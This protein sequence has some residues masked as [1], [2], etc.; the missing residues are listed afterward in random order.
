MHDGDREKYLKKGYEYFQNRN[1]NFQASLR[2]YNNQNRF[3]SNSLFTR[4]LANGEK[5]DR[6]WL[7]YSE[8]TGCVFCYVCKLFSTN[9]NEESKFVKNGFS[10]WKKAK[11]MVNLHENSQEH[12]NCMITWL[13]RTNESNLINKDLAQMVENEIHYWTDVLKRV[14]TVI[15]F[16]A[17]RGL[18]FR[19]EDEVIGSANNG[20]Y[21]GLL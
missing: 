12:K 3:I 1:A 17:E 10:N 20:N 18:A 13:S 2:K 15:R 5:H 9:A 21:M 11:E 19:G 14:V 8:S 7:M 4:V 6:K 16:L